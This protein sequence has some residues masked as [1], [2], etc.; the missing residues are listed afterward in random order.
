MV[1]DVIWRQLCVSMIW[2]IVIYFSELDKG[3]T[4]DQS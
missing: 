2:N 4:S 1:I 3:A